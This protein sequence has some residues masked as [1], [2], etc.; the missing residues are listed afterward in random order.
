MAEEI[1][2]EDNPEEEDTQKGKY[3]T[4]KSGHE[5]FGIE[6]RYINEIIGMQSITA[7][8]EVEPVCNQCQN[9]KFCLSKRREFFTAFAQIIRI[10][11]P[12]FLR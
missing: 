5:Y 9:M 4:F 6:I 10:K 2:K 8:P 3:M 12:H 11:K 1:I 7:I